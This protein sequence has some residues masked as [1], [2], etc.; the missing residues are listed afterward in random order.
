MNII[1]HIFFLIFSIYLIILALVSNI[2]HTL[3]DLYH[4]GPP[5]GGT[6]LHSIL[7]E[8]FIFAINPFIWKNIK[9]VDH[10]KDHGVLYMSN[11]TSFPDGQAALPCVPYRTKFIG[12]TGQFDTMIF[13]TIFET[14]GH[15][16][17]DFCKEKGFCKNPDKMF[18]KCKK[19][20]DS[21]KSVF[22]YPEGSFK[23]YK[24]K[25]GFL[26]FAIKYNIPIQTIR[27]AD[28]T[29]VFN[30]WNKTTT[31]TDAVFEFKEYIKE[32][33]KLTL[34]ELRHKIEQ[35]ILTPEEIE[36]GKNKKEKKGHINFII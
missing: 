26:K 4:F 25:D 11:H 12:S 16:M 5:E 21:G 3:I 32:P 30:I 14:G 22:V 34:E 23:R 10:G 7:S 6:E 36:I 2:L 13:K 31:I 1:G 35:N 8:I 20:L 9:G 24:I 15:I 27:I 28:L 18:E 29:D 19:I 17:V 33:A